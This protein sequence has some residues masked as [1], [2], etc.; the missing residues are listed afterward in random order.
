MNGFVMRTIAAISIGLGSGPTTHAGE[1]KANAPFLPSME[2]EVLD[3]NVDPV[4]NPAV[5]TKAINTDRKVVEIPPT[6]IVH[7]YYYSGDRS[8]RGPFVPGGP[9]IV[10]AS[11]PKNGERTYIN[12]QMLPGFPTV[13]YTARSIRYDYGAQSIEVEFPLIGKPLILYSQGTKVGEGLKESVK[14]TCTNTRQLIVR[15][16]VPELV[17]KVQESTHNLFINA[18]DAGK[19]VTTTALTPF[20]ALL[21]AVP[22]AQLL[23]RSPDLPEDVLPRAKSRIK[24]RLEREAR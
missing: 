10:V 18:V 14:N 24:E 15:S 13:Y 5:R 16:G 8:F 22:G 3:P 21:S 23:K 2:I 19:K 12:V 20:E 7:R 1:H 9:S 11:H 4:G 17:D 6:I